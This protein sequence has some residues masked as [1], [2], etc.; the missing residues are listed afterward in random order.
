MT[1]GLLF[2]SL[3]L[4]PVWWMGLI[5]EWRTSN[6]RIRAE[7]RT[8]GSAV[9]QDQYELRHYLSQ[10]LVLGVL[11]S[12]LSILVGVTVPITWWIMYTVLALLG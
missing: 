7:R 1:I 12:S 3:V 6:H 11:A 5:R 10:S 8:F 9:Y 2:A 4:Q